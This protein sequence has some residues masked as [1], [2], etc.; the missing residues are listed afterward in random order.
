[1]TIPG[2]TWIEVGR[3]VPNDVPNTASPEVHRQQVYSIRVPVDRLEQVRVL[4][5]G[6]G[7]KPTIMLRGWILERLDIE[8]AN[9]T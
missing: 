6:R 1:M 4:A 5:K 9:L 3:Y 2:M 7:V 8:T